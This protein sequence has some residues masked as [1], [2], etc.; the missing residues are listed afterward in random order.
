MLSY[1]FVVCVVAN[2]TIKSHMH[3]LNVLNMMFKKYQS[4]MFGSVQM[5]LF[6]VYKLIIWI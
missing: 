5:F 4:I 6:D 1:I 2:I 3:Q